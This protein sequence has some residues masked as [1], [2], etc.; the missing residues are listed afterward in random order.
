M[1]VYIFFQYNKNNKVMYLNNLFN[2]LQ[3]SFL[4]CQLKLIN[5]LKKLD[6]KKKFQEL[7]AV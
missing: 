2:D 3:R 7:Y 4:F 5:K 6:I 1:F